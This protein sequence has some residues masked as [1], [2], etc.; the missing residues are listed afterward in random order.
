MAQKRIWKNGV[1]ESP[2]CNPDLQFLG[3]QL[4]GRECRFGEHPCSDLSEAVSCFLAELGPRLDRPYTVFGHSMG[5]T[6]ALELC[7]QLH[8]ADLPKPKRVILSGA[9]PPALRKR[10]ELDRIEDADLLKMARIWGGDKLISL[11]KEF[12][13][14]FLRILRADISALDALTSIHKHL[15][16][17]QIEVHGGDV[18]AIVPVEL[19]QRW[20][21]FRDGISVQVHRGGHFYFQDKMNLQALCQRFDPSL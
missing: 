21:C 19:L 18:D 9:P 14:H 20:G 4:P 2:K 15:P 12:Q 7:E 11:P 1:Q 16:D 3:M 6:L 17:L 13:Y 8:A 5:A 10:F